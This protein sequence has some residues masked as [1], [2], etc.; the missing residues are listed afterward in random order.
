[1]RPFIRSL[2]VA[3]AAAQIA[4]LAGTAQ[5]QPAPDRQSWGKPGI[6]FLQYRTDAVE[7]AW[8]A[9]SAAPVAVASV[10]Q[11]FAMDGQDVFEVMESAKR[12]QYRVW[13]NVADQLEPALESCLRSRGY[14]PFKLTDEQNAQLKQLKRGSASRHRYLYGL[15]ID[16]DVL[17]IQGL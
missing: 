17:K 6:S 4:S 9:G 11:V 12:S 10:D 14:R 1:M 5:A 13:N 16:P 8:L 7:C 3:A 15:A 2:A